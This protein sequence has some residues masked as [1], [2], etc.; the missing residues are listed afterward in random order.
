MSFQSMKSTTRL[1]LA[2]LLCC[3]IHSHAQE[4]VI[5]EAEFKEFWTDITLFFPISEKI[6]IGGDAGIRGTFTNNVWK[7]FY[8][9]PQ[10]HYQLLPKL[11]LT[12]GIA[13]FNTFNNDIG[14]V[15]EFRIFQDANLRWP[16]IKWVNI[17]HR[18][19]LE[20]RFLGYQDDIES[21]FSFRGRYLIGVRSK[22]FSLFGGEKDW[23][24][25]GMFEP[26][27]PLGKDVT[28]VLANRTRWYFALG[29]EISQNLRIELHYIGQRSNLLSVDDLKTTETIF[30]FRVFQK[31]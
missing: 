8:I 6:S 31:L 22:N 1:F 27:F 16:E 12:G 26:F 18:L 28:E 19:R 30:R 10:I 15:Y 24:V 14:N 4:D 3:A 13:S 20:Q 9:R 5:Q 2:I 17:F 23:F 7:Q 11:S 21:S 25:T 29:Y